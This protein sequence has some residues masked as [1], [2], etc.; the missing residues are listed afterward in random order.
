[1]ETEDTLLIREPESDNKGLNQ[2]AWRYG[3]RLI[4]VGALTGVA[5]NGEV[6]KQLIELAPP[7]PKPEGLVGR[8]RKS[9]IHRAE[10]ST[11]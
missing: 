5:E 3:D 9:K 11:F 8:P 6:L 4:M 10:Y 2:A 1:M 7:T